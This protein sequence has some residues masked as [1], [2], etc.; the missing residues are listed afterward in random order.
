MPTVLQQIIPPLV[1]AA[2]IAAI[3]Y[4]I[5]LEKR[6]SALEPMKVQVGEKSLPNA[7]EFWDAKHGGWR[8]ISVHVE[9]AEPFKRQPIVS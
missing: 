7:E 9:F 8:K 4:V 6:M 2:I 3:T 1:V 5:R